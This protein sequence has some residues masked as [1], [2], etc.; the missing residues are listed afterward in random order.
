MRTGVSIQGFA[1]AGLAGVLLVTMIELFAKG[2]SLGLALVFASAAVA[3]LAW[4]LAMRALFPA[5][6]VRAGL[7]SAPPKPT[8]HSARVTSVALSGVLLPLLIT[9]AAGLVLDDLLRFS[10]LGVVLASSGLIAIGI[11][12]VRRT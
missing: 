2:P 6:F 10:I 3:I 8:S 7:V 9:V 11:V 1:L 4:A 5:I 12:A